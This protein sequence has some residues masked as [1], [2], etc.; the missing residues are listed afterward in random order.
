MRFFPSLLALTLV[1]VGR[2]D[3]QNPD[4]I[5]VNGAIS[6]R[7]IVQAVR[8]PAVDLRN[9]FAVPSII[10]PVV[11]F[12]TA[13]VGSFNVEMNT[14]V[15]PNTVTN[16]L[17]YVNSNRLANTLVH[18]ANT[19]Y[20]IIQGGGYIPNSTGTTFTNYNTVAKDPALAMEAGDT[21]THTRGTIAMARTSASL[22]TATSEWFINTADNSG[23]FNWAPAS[24]GASNSYAVFGRVT[25][26]GMS[27]VDTIAGY[28]I[29]GGTILVTSSSTSSALIT[30]DAATLPSNFGPGWG[31]L[32]AQVQNVSGNFV[33][34]TRNADTAIS[35][36]TTVRFSLFGAPFDELPVFHNLSSWGNGSLNLSELIKM[37]G[38]STVPIFPAAAGDKSVVTFSATS[39]DPSLV[40]AIV[41]GS[42][43]HVAAA[44]NVTGSAVITVTA[45]DTNGNSRQTAFNVN[46]TR[47]VRD[48]NNDGKVDF[49]FQ[50]NAG[51]IAAWFL[52]N[53]GATIGTSTL[54]AAGLGDWRVM[55]TADMNGDGIA[56]FIFQ[57][58]A[59]QIA[60]WYLN[61]SGTQTSSAI[62][63]PGGLGDW[64]IAA[65]ADING[66]GNTDLIFQNTIG[67]I[68]VWFMNGAGATTSTAY[69]YGGGLG[70]WRVKCTADMNGDG[71]ADLVFQNNI[72]QVA[73]WTLSPTG[74]ISAST[75][76]YGSGLGDWRVVGA[77]DINGDG[78]ADLLFQNYAGQIAAW[79]LNASGT[80]TGIATLNAYGLGDWRLR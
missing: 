69:L 13:G 30:V 28:P 46:V 44:K 65:T 32:G 80:T 78:I 36:P 55:A 17:A 2:V 4:P 18:R 62:I 50:N 6:D 48:F 52:N 34:L 79:Y 23:P 33:T 56:D 12:T 31:L 71:I 58:N 41:L 42:N 8:T 14:G 47:Q 20:R 35:A 9:V 16:F 77:A 51:Q 38:V 25:G 37:T 7:N 75:I 40:S 49:V 59:G 27:V 29:L 5:T 63:Y 21:L 45:T 67:Q 61:A 68:A 70:D 54:Y 1:F 74:A 39:S 24:A 72:G 10:G 3:G 11:Q 26:T 66:D 76:F 15:A 53:S 60:V 43:L 64:R 73:V 57:N 19:T 22:N